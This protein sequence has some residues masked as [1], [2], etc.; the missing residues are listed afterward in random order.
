MVLPSRIRVCNLSRN[1]LFLQFLKQTLLTGTYSRLITNLS[2][3]TQQII[4]S[5]S[6]KPSPPS[7]PTAQNLTLGSLKSSV[8]DLQKPKP[9]TLKM[10]RTKPMSPRKRLMERMKTTGANSSKMKL[11]SNRNQPTRRTPFVYTSLLYTNQYI[12]SLLIEQCSQERG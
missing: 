11:P 4:Y 10:M 2:I 9:R 8:P 6:S 5:I 1:V 3:H 12:P 7:L